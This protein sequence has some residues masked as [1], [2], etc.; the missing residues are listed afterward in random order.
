MDGRIVHVLNGTIY[1]KGGS[2]IEIHNEYESATQLANFI[3]LLKDQEYVLDDNLKAMTR[4]EKVLD[5]KDFLLQLDKDKTSEVDDKI[6]K[7]TTE[8]SESDLNER[9]VFY[10]NDGLVHR[11]GDE[12]LVVTNSQ[13]LPCN[14]RGRLVRVTSEYIEIANLIDR[15]VTIKILRSDI[16][17][18]YRQDE[19]R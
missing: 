7:D 15:T 11:V 8:S 16:K 6:L 2:K 4:T 14:V 5:L 17:L 19:L 9:S 12:I 13:E 10:S 3:K 1:S 18:T